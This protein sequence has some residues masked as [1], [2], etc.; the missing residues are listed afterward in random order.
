MNVMCHASEGELI[1]NCM[2]SFKNATAVCLGKLRGGFEFS[3]KKTEAVKCSREPAVNKQLLNEVFV[4]SGII[5][6]GPGKCRQP[7][8]KAEAHNSQR[9]LDYSGYHKNRI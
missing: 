5:K 8:A 3:G 2:E 4:I 9:D 7:K 1:S 6:K